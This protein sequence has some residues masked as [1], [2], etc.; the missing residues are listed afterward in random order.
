MFYRIWNIN[1]QDIGINN[2]PVFYKKGALTDYRIET[3]GDL[4]FDLNNIG[5]Y[6]HTEDELSGMDRSLPLCTA[7]SKDCLHVSK[8]RSYSPASIFQ[9]WLRPFKCHHKEVKS[10]YYSLFVCKKACF[11][12]NT[13]QLKWEFNWTDDALKKLFLFSIHLLLNHMSGPLISVQIYWTIYSTKIQNYT[14]SSTL[15]MIYVL[16]ANVNQKQYSI[17][18]MSALIQFLSGKVSDYI[19]YLGQNSRYTLIWWIYK[20]VFYTRTSPT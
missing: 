17:S 5:S 4:R 1:N 10:L 14:K 6:E 13:R 3:V 2:K 11:P 9:N 7:R 12:N 15:Q 19:T 8:S 20:S 16:S 18:F